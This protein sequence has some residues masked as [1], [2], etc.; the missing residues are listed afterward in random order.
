MSKFIRLATALAFT[1]S[2]G[3]QGYAQI[4]GGQHA[5]EYLRM[6]NSP[7]VSALGGY[8]PASPDNDVTFTLQNPA[9]LNPANHNQLALNYNLYYAGI[10][11]ANL[12]YAY[13]VEPLNTDFGFGVQYYNYGSFQNTDIQGNNLGDIRAADYSINLSASRKYLERWRY[14]ATIKW[15]QS[16]LGDRSAIGVLA[17]V[18]IVYEDTANL[19][20][21]GVVAKNMGVMVKKYN[22]ETQSEPMP[23]DLQVGISKQLRNLPLR[24]F[25]VGHNLYEWDVRY[26][27]PADKVSN[28]LLPTAEDTTSNKK[29]IADKIFR[30]LNFGVEL[31]LGKRITVSAAYNHIRRGELAAQDAKGLAGFSFGAGVN[32]NKLQVHYARSYFASAGAYNELGLSFQLNKFFNIGKKTEAWGWNKTY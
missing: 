31:I 8:V 9:L 18:G 23:F 19:W 21:F 10:G 7:H 1:I 27:N 30:H 15:A 25:I 26:N 29:Y 14:G 22:P 24:I 5:F 13:H 4:T 32:L 20:T 11:I 3:F 16:I 17:D 2:P 12:Q 28:S 6:S